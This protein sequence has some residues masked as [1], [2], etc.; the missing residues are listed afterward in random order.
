MTRALLALE[1]DM[2]GPMVDLDLHIMMED[3]KARSRSIRV[4]KDGVYRHDED[5]ANPYL[6]VSEIEILQRTPMSRLATI[7]MPTWLA[8]KRGLI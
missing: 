4:S 3:T 1:T 5:A 2:K 8:K 6:P 7:R